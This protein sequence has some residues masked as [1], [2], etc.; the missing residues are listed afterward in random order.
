[1][2]KLLYDNTYPYTVRCAYSRAKAQAVYRNEE[3]AFEFA[4]WI[5]VWTDSGVFEHRGK[6]PHQ[7]C[8][9]RPDPIEAWSPANC[10]IIPRRMLMK[11]NIYEAIH[12]MPK[13]DFEPRHGYYIPP[14]TE[15]K[16]E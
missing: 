16:Y 1:M 6:Q 9:V 7:Y 12:H 2:P 5:Q 4:S 10:I 15:A 14:E 8:M 13:R 3:W 11:K